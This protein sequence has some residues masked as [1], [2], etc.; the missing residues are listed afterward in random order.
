MGRW[1]LIAL[2]VGL[3]ACGGEPGSGP[4]KPVFGNG[5]AGAGSGGVGGTSVGGGAGGVAGSGGVGGVGASGGTSGSGGTSASGGSGG[6]AG[7]GGTTAAGG[8]GGAPLGP[9]CPSGKAGEIWSK[10]AGTYKMEALALGSGTDAFWTVGKVYD[11]TV[12]T[13]DCSIVFQ[14]NGTP[15]VCPWTGQGWNYAAETVPNTTWTIHIQDTT[16]QTQSTSNLCELNYRID[17]GKMGTSAF[18]LPGTNTG[19]GF[20]SP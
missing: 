4:P 1:L 5:G 14:T 18:F 8:S 7:A 10:L 3:S 16:E 20:D 13:S 6:A 9:G 15:Q 12:D 2:F 11:V 17:L 19:A